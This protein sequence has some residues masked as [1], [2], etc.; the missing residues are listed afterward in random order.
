[1]N[2]VNGVA[3]F[4]NL[5][6][7]T[8][9]SYTLVVS[10]SSLTG[11]TSGNITISGS[12]G[13]ASNLAITQ[14]PAT[15]TAGQALST[16][17]TVAIEDASSNVVTGNSSTVT[18]T[19][20]NGPSGFATGST[21]SAAAVNGVASFSNLIFDTAGTYTLSVNDGSLAGATSAT[22]TISPAAA[23][24]LAITRSPTT[25]TAG[26]A[27]SPSMEVAVEDAFGNV[28]TSNT[29]TITLIVNSGPDGFASGSTVNVAAVNGVATFS[30]LLCDRTGSYVIGAS[31]GSLTKAVSASITIAPAAA[32]KLVILKTPGRG[33]AGKPLSSLQAAVEDQYGNIVTSDS[34]IIT[35]SVSSG[36]SG[37]ESGSTTKVAAVNGIVTFSKLILAHGTYTLKVSDGSLTSAISYSISVR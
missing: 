35:V 33:T 30:N 24:N 4:S 19:V 22:I 8:A 9:G 34:S 26:Q 28:V 20:T 23:S 25:G 2:A 13:I 27:L 17:L 6:L 18:V 10:D 32:S 5:I 21:T 3:I 29:S 31:D 1:M 11:A 37:F 14:T 36:P 16:A 7:N 12:T 15:G